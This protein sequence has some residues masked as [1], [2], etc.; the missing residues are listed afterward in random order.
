M[1]DYQGPGQ[2]GGRVV[3]AIALV[4][5]LVV[6]AVVFGGVFLLARKGALATLLG[7]PTAASAAEEAPGPTW[8]SVPAA[9]AQPTPLLLITATPRFPT[10]TPVGAAQQATLAALTPTGGASPTPAETPSPT[11]TENAATGVYRVEYMGCTKHASNTGTVKGQVFDRQ[12]RVVVGAE[13][14]ISIDDWAYDKPAA[15]NGEGWYEF[16]LQKGQRIKVRALRIKGVDV[17]LTGADQQFKA[18]GGCF[19]YVNLREE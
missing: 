19:E 6:G 17:A 2:S 14:F 13:V 3:L 15:S 12:G 11:A 4:T 1:D 8:T 10:A 18:Q 7:E 5:L 9:A 16:Y